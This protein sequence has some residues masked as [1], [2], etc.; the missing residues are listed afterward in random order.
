MLFTQ[1]D[2]HVSAEMLFEEANQTRVSVSLATVYNALR[3]FTEVGLLRQVA[4]DSLKTY[5]D[6]NNSEHHH[7]YLE[8]RRGRGTLWSA[9]HRLRPMASKLLVLTS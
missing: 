5:F 1:G 8:D 9:E 3:D 4:V 6:T 2:R 7:Y